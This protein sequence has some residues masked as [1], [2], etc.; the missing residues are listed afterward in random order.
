MDE[1]GNAG[2]PRKLKFYKLFFPFLILLALG[3]VGYTDIN[4]ARSHLYWLAMVPVFAGACLLLEWLQE[5]NRGLHWAAVLRA[6][7]ML[8]LSLLVG[9]FLVYV[10]LHSGRLDNENAGLIVLLLLA[11][12]VFAA[13]LQLGPLVMLLGGFLALSLVL[14]AYIESYVWLIM[15]GFVVGIGV[16]SYLYSRRNA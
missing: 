4:P 5:H 9:V 7:L 14:A 13:G 8:W 15:L 12:T 6:Q 11:M 10:L 1:S 3:G 2:A 16:L